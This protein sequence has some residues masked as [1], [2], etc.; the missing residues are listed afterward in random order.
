MTTKL[1]LTIHEKVA[2]EIKVFRAKQNTSV[3]KI[4]E[5]YFKN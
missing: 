5:E 1:N 3:S 4:A 2:K